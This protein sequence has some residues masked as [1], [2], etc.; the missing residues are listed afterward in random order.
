M[1]RTAALLT[2][3]LAATAVSLA[4]STGAVA[5][6]SLVK[7]S[8]GPLSATLAPSTHTPKVNAKW[9]ITVTATLQG[10][11]AHASAFYE[12]LFGGAVVSTQYIGNNRHYSFTG[13]F[14]DQLV[15]PPSAAG[16]PLTLD[17]VIKA[18]GHTVNLDW[19]IKAHT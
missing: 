7:E 9:P 2:T 18:A 4:V 10:K 12:F 16:E 13:H 14:S 6:G 17:V 11:P 5:S 15:F 8:S 1:A 3:A 19:S